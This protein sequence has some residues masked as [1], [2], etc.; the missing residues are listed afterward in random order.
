MQV[1]Q[2]HTVITTFLDRARK[3]TF[4]E[5]DGLTLTGLT[6]SEA[7]VVCIVLDQLT[8]DEVTAI[9]QRSHA[10]G[11]QP[12]PTPA[13]SPPAAPPS[14]APR[15]ASSSPVQPLETVGG[16][17]MAPQRAAAPQAPS[18]TAANTSGKPAQAGRFEPIPVDPAAEEHVEAVTRKAE[19]APEPAAVISKED[20]EA[21]EAHAEAVR[22]RKKDKAQRK[23][24]EDAR[25]DEAKAPRKKTATPG[26]KA[27]DMHENVMVTDVKSHSDGGCLLVRADGWRI[28][29]DKNGKEVKRLG[30]APPDVSDVVKPASELEEKEATPAKE[31]ERKAY[32][33]PTDVLEDPSARTLLTYLVD[34]VGI[35]GEDALV[36][37]CLKLKDKGAKAFA[38]SRDEVGVRRRVKASLTVMGMG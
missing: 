19:P 7:R 17:T 32:T 36:L 16:P 9:V 22:K 12:Q 15:K 31:E 25:P 2:S 33:V 37:E 1:I 20:N 28:K 4:N 30:G 14:P 6:A 8:Q 10:A 27:G 23:V 3:A 18:A 35:E 11:P 21:A 24:V 38:K 26:H 29:L 5:L 34:K 13:A